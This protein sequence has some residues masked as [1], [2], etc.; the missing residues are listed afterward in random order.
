MIDPLLLEGAAEP[1]VDEVDAVAVRLLETHARDP[2]RH[3]ILYRTPEGELLEDAVW[4]WSSTPDRYLDTALHMAAASNPK[5]RV[6]DT[7]KV[8]SLAANLLACYL[9][10]VPGGAGRHL[11]GVVELR[12][13]DP[14]HAVRPEILRAEE[15]VSGELPGNL[16]VAMGRLMRRLA[17]DCLAF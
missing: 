9:E 13:T 11:V 4:R 16:A 6:A 12:I 7:S 8:S 1:V 10:S 3:R 14:D 5:V 17:A 15:A 2:I